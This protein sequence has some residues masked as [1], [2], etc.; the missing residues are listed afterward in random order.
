MTRQK[1]FNWR[2]NL[3]GQGILE[4][5]IAI[6]V[7][8]TGLIGSLSL[9]MSNIASA[10]ENEARVQAFNFAREALEIVRNFRDTNWLAEQEVW[11]GLKSANTYEG[12]TDYTAVLSFDQQSQSWQLDFRPD[13]LGQPATRLYLVNDLI[14]QPQEGGQALKFYRLITLSP[15]C[16]DEEIIKVDGQSCQ[17]DNPQIG[18]KVKVALLWYQHDKKKQATLEED[19]YNWR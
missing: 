4:V 17:S 13:V 15:I 19:L 7:I 16:Q 5:I 6:G 18:I 3:R 12:G 8:A 2:E 11:T 9:A 1:K 10:Q 14:T